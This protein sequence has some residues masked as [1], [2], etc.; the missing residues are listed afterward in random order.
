MGQGRI[1]RQQTER[2]WAMRLLP[3]ASSRV[4]AL[5]DRPI[6][7]P[8]C[9]AHHLV[10]KSKGGVVT[11]HM[12]RLCHKQVHAVLTETELARHYATPQALRGHPEI[13]RFIQ[14]VKEKPDDFNP[15][16]R[17]SRNKGV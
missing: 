15:P 9:D 17:A 4:C 12:H 8:L 14:W 1:K 13:A 2:E 10:P 16:T 7:P 11:V 5:C 6:P 3:L